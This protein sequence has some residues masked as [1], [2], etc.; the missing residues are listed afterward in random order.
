MKFL[1]LNSKLSV[2]QLAKNI[3]RTVHCDLARAVNF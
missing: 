3:S 2:N 1:K